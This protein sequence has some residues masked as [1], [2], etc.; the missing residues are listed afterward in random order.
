MRRLLRLGLVLLAVAA[1]YLG[2]TFVQ[3]VQAAQADGPPEPAEAIIVLGAA[4]YGGRPSPVLK[5][6]L[7]H[8]LA[9]FEDDLAPVIAVTGGR[10]AGD[11]ATEASAAASY[12]IG[13][14]VP[15]EALLLESSGTNSWQSLAAAARF[16]REQEI[17]DV[18]LVSSPY[19]A[20]RTEHIAAEVGLHGSA[21]P[22][23]GARERGVTQLVTMGR[24]TLAVGVGRII[25]YRRLV[26]LDERV[27]QVRTE[28]GGG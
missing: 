12:L 21:S 11:S 10:K 16:L 14:G 3:V 1:A 5:A 28:V 24:E 25:G 2:F 27:G 22:A 6:R 26:N 4:Q 23:P 15:E 13:E 7:D 9:L 19:H 20:L 17:D 18:I 8:A